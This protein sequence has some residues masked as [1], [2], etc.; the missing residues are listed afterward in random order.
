MV[1][2]F[3]LT[4]VFLCVL[5][6]ESFRFNNVNSRQGHFLLYGGGGFGAPKKPAFKYTGPL[7]PGV[8]GPKLDVPI[9]IQRP[10]YAKDG[11]PKLGANKGNLWDVKP[12]A[13]EDIPRMRKAGK[14]AREVLDSAIRMVEP[15]L[16][17][18]EIDAH[19]HKETIAR[20]SYPSPL[21]Y[22]G[23]P[24]SCCTSI[25]EIICHGIPDTTVLKEGD[26]MNIDVTIYHD[27]V[28]GDCSET[29][30]VGGV[31]KCD[32]KIVDLVKTTY[33][34]WKAAIDFCAP[35]KKYNEIGGI[36]EDIIKPKGYA[37]VKEFCG[38]GIGRVFHSAPNVLHYRNQQRLGIMA[39]GHTFTIEPM[40]CMKSAKPVNWPDDWTAA[41]SDGLPTAQFEH[42]LLI[43]ETGVEEL[44]GKLADSP[45]YGW[46]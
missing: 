20:D 19:V 18:M 8:V 46:E 37:S 7:K 35:G 9:T 25:N 40:I 16:T 23:F 13:E 26:I 17:T 41:T 12:C 38:H 10:D 32:P 15:G 14:I 24:K 4:T 42:T 11:V 44:T 43:T 45:K 6:T 3:H 5:I 33:D 27:G 1:F 22:H 36:I 21:N 39:P 28:H 34:A 2:Y 29:V 31:D 30:F